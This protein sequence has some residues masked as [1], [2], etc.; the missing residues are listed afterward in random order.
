MDLTPVPAGAKAEGSERTWLG[1]CRSKTGRKG[2]GVPAR[3]YREI[4]HEPVLGGKA[5]GGPALTAAGQAVEAPR[6]APRAPPADRA[7]A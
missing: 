7:P 5:A 3:D 2:L 4:L 6:G 1:R